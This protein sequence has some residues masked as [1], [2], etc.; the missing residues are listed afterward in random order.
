MA[1]P[2]VSAISA[3]VLQS[4][5]A[6]KQSGVESLLKNAAGGLPLP[7]CDALV[8]FPF[9]SE[10][11]YSATWNGGEWGAGFIQANAALQKAG[12]KVK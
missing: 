12:V 1:A 6:L 4:C 7:A 3:L 5:P 10:G 11:Y 9:I 2:H 8:A